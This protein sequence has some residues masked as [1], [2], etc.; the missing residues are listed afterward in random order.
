MGHKQRR[1]KVKARAR[2]LVDQLCAMVAAEHAAQVRQIELIAE[3]C[4]AYSVLDAVGPVLPGQERLIPAG[5]DGTPLVAEHLATEL[6]PKLRRTI[7]A[8]GGWISQAMDLVCRH[9][10][11]WHACQ[12]GRL[13]V[14]QATHLAHTTSSAGLSAP[15]AAWVDEKLDPA[16][17][18]LSFGRLKRKLSG[19]LLRADVE[20]A[21]RRAAQA[22][23]ERFVRVRHLG[24]GTAF[25]TARTDSVDAHRLCRTLDHLAGHLSLAGDLDEVDVLRAKALGILAEPACAL[26]LLEGPEPDPTHGHCPHD[27]AAATTSGTDSHTDPATAANPGTRTRR[28]SRPRPTAE[29]VIHYAP[30]QHVG[31]CEELGPVLAEQVRHWLGHHRVV[32]RPVIDLHDN[33]AV[34]NY[35]IPDWLARIVRLR[36]PYDIFPWSS[37]T[38]RS[39]DLDHTQPYDHSPDAPA[40]QTCPDNLA[41]LT[42]RAHRAKTH[43]GWEV[44]QPFPGVFDWR[45]PLGYHYRVDHT[46]SQELTDT[47]KPKTG[48]LDPRPDQPVQTQTQD[49]RSR[50][51]EILIDLTYWGPEAA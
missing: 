22:R 20:L 14:W 23:A 33:P 27:R 2:A 1:R 15:A 31:R 18:H 19:L 43:S 32:V 28:R 50:R 35:E 46:G 10:R 47:K 29:L 3:L 38:S 13:P 51:P 48:Q 37:R 17:G 39:L 8:T 24:D 36:H 42:R 34:D 9:P 11:L 30:G 7:E 26:A 25:L 6:A 49:G 21:T 5:A 16:V 40:G 41:P 12:T 4:Q 45:S 44:A